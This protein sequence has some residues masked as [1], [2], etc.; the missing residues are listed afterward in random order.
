MYKLQLTKDELR[1]CTDIAVNRW[2]VKFGS[3]DRPNYAQGK[4]DGRLEHE[5]TANVRTIVAEYA[6]AKLTNKPFNL[7]WYPNEMHP[8]RKDLPD[9]GG[10]ME[11]RTVRTYDEVPIWRKDSGKAIVGCKVTD[12]EYFTEVEI[13]GWVMADDIINNDTYAD[14]YIGG[15]RYPLSSLTP[16]PKPTHL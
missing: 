10:N 16:F 6:V 8:H 12:D 11:V 5:L 13:Y 1:M 7:P 4:K 14:S 9:V 15:W 2:L 3:T